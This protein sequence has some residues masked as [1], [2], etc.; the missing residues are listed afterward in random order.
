MSTFPTLSIHQFD[1]Q[2]LEHQFYVNTFSEHLRKHHTSILHPHKHDFYLTV[3]F[4]HG[5]GFHEIDF[6]RF[7][8][9][10]GAVF[11]LQP[12][13]T[14]H[15]EFSEAVEGFIFFHSATYYQLNF[16]HQRLADFPFLYSRNDIPTL[17]LLSDEITAFSQQFEE[18][19]E[20]FTHA[21]SHKY[22]KIASL[23]NCLYIDLSRCYVEQ[24]AVLKEVAHRYSHKFEAFE[25][26][27]NEQF[28]TQKS[29][30]FYADQLNIGTK[31]LNRICRESSGKTSTEF[32]MERVILE[33]K[34]LL[35]SEQH[36][37][38][39]IALVL[40]FEEYTYFSRLFKQYCHESPRDFRKRYY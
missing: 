6:Q 29:A 39:E 25:S 34:R 28:I 7:E 23:L 21:K 32:I 3:L 24:H 19:L 14:H 16:P 38:T 20:E 17:Q 5:T 33:A 18:L 30:A 40:G 13:Q 31:H 8:V 26:L 11:F 9:I 37:L 2:G 15:W 35:S 27:V 1:A 10:P 22:Q 36:N 12:G 4:T